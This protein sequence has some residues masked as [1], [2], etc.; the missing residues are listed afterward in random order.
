MRNPN[1]SRRRSAE[2]AS[3]KNDCL[4]RWCKNCLQ[5]KP[6]TDFAPRRDRKNGRRYQCRDC[7]NKRTAIWRALNPA[8]AREWREKKRNSG[9]KLLTIGC[10]VA[11]TSPKATNYMGRWSQEHTLETSH[12]NR[13]ER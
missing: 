7:D 11:M 3:L 4:V 9:A 8:Y 10:P 12:E 1:E 2:A 6:L 5:T 13:V